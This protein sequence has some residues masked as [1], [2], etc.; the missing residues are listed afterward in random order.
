MYI[1]TEKEIVNLDH[2]TKISYVSDCGGFVVSAH[3]GGDIIRVDNEENAKKCIRQIFDALVNN[4]KAMDI[5]ELE[6]I[7]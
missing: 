4:R 7:I 5:H 2:A 3:P 6:V 1:F